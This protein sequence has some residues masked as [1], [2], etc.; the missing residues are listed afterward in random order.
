MQQVKICPAAF[1]PVWKGAV[2]FPRRRAK[3][4]D[5]VPG[6]AVCTQHLAQ[7][8]HHQVGVSSI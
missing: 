1:S 2:P 3:L 8:A 7:P 5:V 6:V 4:L